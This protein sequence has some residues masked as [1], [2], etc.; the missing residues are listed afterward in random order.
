M[1]KSHINI[2]T[3]NIDNGRVMIMFRITVAYK[4]TM[5]HTLE[6]RSA[7]RASQKKEHTH[8][9]KHINTQHDEKVKPAKEKIHTIGDGGTRQAENKIDKISLCLF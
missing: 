1:A 4:N 8:T 5:P 9:Y 7:V 2:K 6:F 3:P